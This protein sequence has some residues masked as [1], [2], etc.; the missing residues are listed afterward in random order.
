[1][2]IML[3]VLSLLLACAVAQTQPS[4]SKVA[5]NSPGALES[6]VRAVWE[7]FQKKDKAAV[8]KLL[9]SDFRTIEE[10]D[11]EFTEKAAELK[12]VDDYILDQY[13]LTDFQTKTIG[14]NAALVTYKAE[15]SGKASGQPVHVRGTFGEVWVKR[16]GDWK[17]LYAQETTLH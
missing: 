6:K 5:P 8:D 16:G 12:Q 1:M 15:F 11:S 17:C 14:P 3:T 7:G 9:D 13:T 10:G 2:K 4:A